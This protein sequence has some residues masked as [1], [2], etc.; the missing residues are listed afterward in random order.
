MALRYLSDIVAR[1]PVLREALAEYN[2]GPTNRSPYYALTVLENYTRVL[3]HANLGCE[4]ERNPNF[5]LPQRR[6]GAKVTT[7]AS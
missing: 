2:G 4:P 5:A 6:R 3:R 1:R 7:S